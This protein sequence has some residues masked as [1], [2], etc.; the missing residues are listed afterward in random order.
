MSLYVCMKG[1][2]KYLKSFHGPPL[3]RRIFVYSLQS[4]KY[5]QIFQFLYVRVYMYESAFAE[6]QEFMLIQQDILEYVL[7]MLYWYYGHTP[8]P[9]SAFGSSN[10]SYENMDILLVGYHFSH[11]ITSAFFPFSLIERLL[12]C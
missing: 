9:S 3:G 10:Q 12:L 5:T 7:L 6:I 2:L 4:P 11:Y 8:N 1:W